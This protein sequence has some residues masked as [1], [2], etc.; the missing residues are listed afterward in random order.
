MWAFRIALTTSSASSCCCC[1]SCSCRGV[2]RAKRAGPPIVT[3]T[4]PCRS[5]A[6]TGPACCSS[7]DEAVVVVVDA[8]VAALLRGFVVVVVVAAGA[9][10]PSF[11]VAPPEVVGA[12]SSVAMALLRRLWNGWRR[13]GRAEIESS[14]RSAMP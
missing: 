3:C 8:A 9:A 5:C 7:D 10:A 14:I 12:R 2:A 11:R 13:D 4:C 6:K 1:W